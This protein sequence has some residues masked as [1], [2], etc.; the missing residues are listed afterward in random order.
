MCII[1]MYLLGVAWVCERWSHA[2]MVSVRSS[3][4]HIRWPKRALNTEKSLQFDVIMW[5]HI[6]D[7]C[8]FNNRENINLKHWGPVRAT[9]SILHSFSKELLNS[10]AWKHCLII[11]V[12]KGYCYLCCMLND[13]SYLLYAYL[14]IF[15]NKI[16]MRQHCLF[17]HH[18][19]CYS[20]IS[21][22]FY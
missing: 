4:S 18:R 3:V 5:C 14:N 21:T 16:F 22:L 13:L 2:K 17:T 7:K 15:R 1:V 19:Q 9:E 11:A 8:H 10:F 6:Y 12:V 20:S